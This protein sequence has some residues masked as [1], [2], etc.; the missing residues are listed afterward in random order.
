[1][2]DERRDK[3]DTGEAELKRL[4]FARELA[5]LNDLKAKTDRLEARVGDDP[6]LSRSM[7]DVLVEVLQ[8]SDA[9]DHERLAAALTPLIISSMHNEIRHSR[10]V[11][12]E[13]LT[14]IAGQVAW[15]SILA[16]LRRPICALDGALASVFSINRWRA[17]LGSAF[18]KQSQAEIL[19]SLDPTFQINAFMLADRTTGEP[20][21]SRV[22]ATNITPDDEADLFSGY[23]NAL[24][25]F[26]Q[27]ALFETAGGDIRRLTSGDTDLFL[28][29]SPTLLLAV[30]ASGPL[31]V[32]IELQLEALFVRFLS[33]FR[34]ELIAGVAVD[35]AIAPALESDFQFRLTQ[36]TGQVALAARPPP[37]RGAVAAVIALVLGVGVAGFY[38]YQSW[39][40]ER[41]ADRASALIA[42]VPELSAYQLE[43]QVT[44]GQLTVRGLAPTIETRNQLTADLTAFALKEQI[45][46]VL[47]VDALPSPAVQSAAVVAAALLPQVREELAPLSTAVTDAVFLMQDMNDDIVGYAARIESQQKTL[48]EL[49]GVLTAARGRIDQNADRSSNLAA[50]IAAAERTATRR[51]ERLA[52]TTASLSSTQLRISELL[53]SITSLKTDIADRTAKIVQ[54]EKTLNALQPLEVAAKANE[55]QISLLDTELGKLAS[56]RDELAARLAEN[57]SEQGSLSIAVTAIGTRVNAVDSRTRTT[58]ETVSRAAAIADTA[59]T[60]AIRL[61]RDLSLLQTKTANIDDLNAV[62]SE[63][64]AIKSETERLAQSIAT[65]AAQADV[66]APQLK[67]NT[68]AIPPDLSER[69]ADLEMRAGEA[70]SML[71]QRIDQIAKEAQPR[72]ASPQRVSQERLTPLILRFA[73]STRPSNIDA[74]DETLRRVAEIAL[75]MPAGMMLRVIGYADSDGTVEANRITSK[76]RSDWAVEKLARL[77]VPI[78]RMI[79]VGRG[80]ERLL[81]ADASDSSPNRRVEFEAF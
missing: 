38:G 36:L 7:E 79:S 78:D 56:A 41:I 14:P 67:P 57:E 45:S 43:T 63:L 4:L 74:S 39:T 50:D 49:T 65:T 5:L 47:E 11:M 72:A 19:Q 20:I 52:E 33:A 61:T 15:A 12:V 46:L 25:T 59:Q 48:K 35:A 44:D 26:S 40:Q 3:G 37:W 42:A 75:A 30:S 62:K 1:M 10:P 16:T 69:L 71:D 17:R 23:L 77:G 66:S 53:G 70:I 13:T 64:S 80:A 58:D 21:V 22:L 55:R 60:E 24:R 51:S 31:P 54:V 28:R 8:K 29:T 27:N 32:N 73:E 81:S 68:A 76:R 2:S 18:S 9:N 6:A 34:G